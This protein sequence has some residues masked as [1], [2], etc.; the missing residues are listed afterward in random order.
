MRKRH[1]IKRSER[2][3]IARRLSLLERKHAAVLR[4]R[5]QRIST[6]AEADPVEFMDLAS[7]SEQDEMAVR[8]SEIQASRI[9]QIAEALERLREGQYGICKSCGEEI[10]QRRL[11]AEPSATLC[12]RCKVKSERTMESTELAYD[13]E[14][15]EGMGAF[16]GE[17]NEDSFSNMPGEAGAEEM[18]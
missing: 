7:Y 10:S 17:E 15:V 5:L 6:V 9:S 1:V 13:E 4:Q 8:T 2:A 14:V 3:Q 18:G 12:I 11:A 16:M